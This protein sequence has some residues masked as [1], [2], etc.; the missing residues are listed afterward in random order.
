M[1]TLTGANCLYIEFNTK[2]D[3]NCNFIFLH[4]EPNKKE[5][6]MDFFTQPIQRSRATHV[7]GLLNMCDMKDKRRL[8]KVKIIRITIGP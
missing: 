8:Y 3:Y 1:F 5:F 2:D 6:S 4:S 7:R